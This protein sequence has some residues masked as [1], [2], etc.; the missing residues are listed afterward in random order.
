VK[1]K[2]KKKTKTQAFTDLLL[3]FFFSLDPLLRQFHFRQSQTISLSEPDNLIPNALES[4]GRK[5]DF[6]EYKRISDKRLLGIIAGVESQ[7]SSRF[8]SQRS[9][10]GQDA[11]KEQDPFASEFEQNKIDFARSVRELKAS[12]ENGQKESYVEFSLAVQ[13]A[14]KRIVDFVKA[15]KYREAIESVV[16]TTDKSGPISTPIGKLV[17]LRAE[18]T[19]VQ[20]KLVLG[21]WPPPG[22]E[23]EMLMAATRLVQAVKQFDGQVKQEIQRIKEKEERERKAALDKGKE[24]QQAELQNEKIRK[25]FQLYERQQLDL[26]LV[27]RELRISLS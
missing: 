24:L 22:A 8:E 5:L 13:A 26:T 14:A 9:T 1:V 6:I 10:K 19:V 20:A 16:A 4:T 11:G 3:F 23:E 17:T 27:R 12:K 7:S 2:K 25:L 21:V 18:E 15:S